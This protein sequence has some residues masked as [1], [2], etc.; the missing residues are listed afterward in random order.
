MNLSFWTKVKTWAIDTWAAFELRLAMIWGTLDQK[1]DQKLGF[2][3]A[4]LFGTVLGGGIPAWLASRLVAVGLVLLASWY[5]VGKHNDGVIAKRDAEW[6]AK[7]N[8]EVARVEKQWIE[9]DRK[10]REEVDRVNEAWKKTHDDLSNYTNSIEAILAAERKDNAEL[11]SKCAATQK[12][13]DL[14]RA[15]VQR[16]NRSR[17]PLK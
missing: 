15:K 8:Q 14:L 4:P 5:V 16:V 6:Q 7:L 17:R 10:I 2:V 3:S 13:V 9:R 11:Q 12:T 1:A